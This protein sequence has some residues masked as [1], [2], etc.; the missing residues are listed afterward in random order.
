MININHVIEITNKIYYFKKE[1][2]KLIIHL[3]N[4]MATIINKKKKQKIN[5]I[6]NF[7]NY[8]ELDDWIYDY[9]D[10]NYWDELND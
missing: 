9:D 1:K 2:Q 6:D 3:L 5:E 10:P 8:E 7:N 4:N